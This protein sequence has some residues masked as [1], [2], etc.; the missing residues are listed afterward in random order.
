MKILVMD[1]AGF[2]RSELVRYLKN[3]RG[4]QVLNLN[5]LIYAGNLDSLNSVSG[6]PYYEFI[7]GDICDR[8]LI[9]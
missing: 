7:Q 4:H 2:I 1:G 3:E 6:H 9:N 8:E 5:K